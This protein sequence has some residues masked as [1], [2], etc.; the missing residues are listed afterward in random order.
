MFATNQMMCCHGLRAPR[1]PTWPSCSCTDGVAAEDDHAGD[2]ALV[3]EKD[4]SQSVEACADRIAQAPAGSGGS[5]RSQARSV[6]A[7]IST[8]HEEFRRRHPQVRGPTDATVRAEA[9]GAARFRSPVPAGPWKPR[10]RAIGPA[11]GDVAPAA[12][13]AE[14]SAAAGSARS[15]GSR[16]HQQVWS[17]GQ[18]RSRSSVETWH[19]AES[20][21]GRKHRVSPAVPHRPWRATS[22]IASRN[23]RRRGAPTQGRASDA[24]GM[25]SIR[26]GCASDEPA[27]ASGACTAANR[28]A[29]ALLISQRGSA[30]SALFASAGDSGLERRYGAAAYGALYRVDCQCGQVRRESDGRADRQG[31]CTE[32][33]VGAAAG[34]SRS[35]AQVG[36]TRVAADPTR[37]QVQHRRRGFR[38]YAAVAQPWRWPS[39]S[40]L[41]GSAIGGQAPWR[42]KR[43][44]RRAAVTAGD[45]RRRARPGACPGL[46]PRPERV[47]APRSRY[48]RLEAKARCRAR[49]AARRFDEVGGGSRWRA[50]CTVPRRPAGC[51]NVGDQ[52]RKLADR[53]CRR[54][55]IRCG[56]PRWPSRLQR[57]ALGRQRR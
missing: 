22:T 41:A 45:A 32:T 25:V 47:I 53:C 51:A 3:G 43:L 46:S 44:L 20:A 19:A 29:E 4:P 36:I 30:K 37:Q 21:L 35:I 38:Q 49:H 14:A 18:Q 13:H 28:L 7:F 12:S 52:R 31:S 16:D 42:A 9:A 15:R 26:N 6:T 34:S 50:P 2:A 10:R 24:V 33:A 55:R 54:A 27:L 17:I 39:V 40:Q 1:N 48:V 5:R 56:V 11:P 8:R 57:A 23:P